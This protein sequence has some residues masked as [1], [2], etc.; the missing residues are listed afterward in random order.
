MNAHRGKEMNAMTR[1]ILPLCAAL[2]LTAA[3]AAPSAGPGPQAGAQGPQVVLETSRGT[4][5]IR[6]FPADAPKTVEHMLGLF[7]R[8]FYRGLRFH[9]VEATLVQIGDPLSRDMSRRA[10]W[11]RGGSG[12]R[13]GVAEISKTRRHTRGTVALAHSAGPTTA[14]SQFYIMKAAS[15]SLDGKY[16]IIGQVTSGMDVVDRIVV[17]DVIKQTTVKGAGP[18]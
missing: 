14:D 12:Q 16:A 15:P 6:L 3:A 9:R 17:G 5:E 18:S 11:G 8:N 13:V 10:Y 4:I 7:Q 1:A 2:G